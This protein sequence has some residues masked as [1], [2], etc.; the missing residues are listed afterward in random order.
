MDQVDAM[1]QALNRFIYYHAK[2]KFIPK[3]P[4]TLEEKVHRHII[5]LSRGRRKG[6]QLQ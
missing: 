1:S 3:E 5:R 2:E 6:G 4:V